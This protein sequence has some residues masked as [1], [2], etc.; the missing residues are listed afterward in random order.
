MI[1]DRK[2]VGESTRTS[3]MAAL[4]PCEWNPHED[5]PAREGDPNHGL[6]VWSCGSKDNIH[7]CQSCSLL[8][9]FKRKRAW[10]WIGGDEDNPR[11]KHGIE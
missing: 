7:L 9:R 10:E 4:E 11:R 6:A 8:P 3:S 5:R 1:S 2:N